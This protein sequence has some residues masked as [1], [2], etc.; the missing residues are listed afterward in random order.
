MKHR[1]RDLLKWN[2]EIDIFWN[3]VST[4]FEK[5]RHSV[6]PFKMFLIFGFTLKCIRK[7][8]LTLI[9]EHSFHDTQNLCTMLQQTDLK[10][11]TASIEYF[12]G[13]IFSLHCCI[14]SVPVSVNVNFMPKFLIYLIFGIEFLYIF[15]NR[16]WNLYRMCFCIYR[17]MRKAIY[18][19]YL[20]QSQK[21]Y[22]YR[23]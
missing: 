12:N 2:I 6:F 14:F 1:N 23:K 3:E 13:T 5:M 22:V 19:W 18:W 9:L 16:S 21:S 8:G 10:W 20:I 4:H 15:E 7:K 17:I 11:R